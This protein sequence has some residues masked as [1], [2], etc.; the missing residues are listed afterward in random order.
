MSVT[1]LAD[2]REAKRQDLINEIEWFEF[3]LTSLQDGEFEDVMQ[4]VE[5]A[6]KIKR[7]Q[8]DQT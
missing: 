7:K 6:I 4:A 1:T 3:L 2:Y 5:G 8:L